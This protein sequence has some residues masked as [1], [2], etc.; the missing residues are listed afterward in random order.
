MSMDK[1]SNYVYVDK[2]VLYHK[3]YG[4]GSL[5]VWIQDDYLCT[6]YY[7]TGS[8]VTVQKC[9]NVVSG[10]TNFAEGWNCFKETEDECVVRLISE[11]ENN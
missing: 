9:K 1:E 11:I 5:K 8:N 2:Q 4:C 3:P 10:K 6:I 7:T